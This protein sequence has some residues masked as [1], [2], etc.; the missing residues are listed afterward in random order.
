[1]SCL[2]GSAALQRP[3][4]VPDGTAMCTQQSSTPDRKPR[5]TSTSKQKETTCKPFAHSAVSLGSSVGLASW[6]I[7]RDMA[8]DTFATNQARA[9][10][11][12]R[13]GVP[14]R[15]KSEVS[16]RWHLL[17]RPVQNL[18]LLNHALMDQY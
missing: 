13:L 11:H 6:S 4:S 12:H 1:M 9:P 3:L 5:Q 16:N 2:A 7:S 14:E 17:M 15:V 8:Y 18:G 10:P